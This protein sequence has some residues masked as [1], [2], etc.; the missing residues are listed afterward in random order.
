LAS[1]RADPRPKSQLLLYKN[2][3]ENIRR[4]LCF[5]FLLLF[6]FPLDLP[7]RVLVHFFDRWIRIGLAGR[8][9]S[10]CRRAVIWNRCLTSMVSAGRV[11]VAGGGELD[12]AFTACMLNRRTPGNTLVRAPSAKVSYWRQQETFAKQHATA[13]SNAAPPSLSGHG[14]DFL[15]SFRATG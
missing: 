10:R 15:N 12:C 5:C 13:R 14:F 1:R 7:L 11:A 6:A 2:A 3:A 9:S 8:L 4:I